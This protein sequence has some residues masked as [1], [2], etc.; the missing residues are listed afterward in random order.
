MN[1][2]F[3]ILSWITAAAVFFLTLTSGADATAAV[4][5]TEAFTA[6]KNLTEALEA[7]PSGSMVLDD[8][9]AAAH[10][11][12]ILGYIGPD[13]APKVFPSDEEETLRLL[14]DLSRVI[15]G[16]DACTD[17]RLETA[18]AYY[19]S[20]WC[21][22]HMDNTVSGKARPAVKEYMKGAL[23]DSVSDE[24]VFAATDLCIDYIERYEPELTGSGYEMNTHNANI[25]GDDDYLTWFRRGSRLFDEGKYS[26]AIEAY[27][28]CLVYREN[29]IRA[30]FEI[31][32]AYI[33]MRK[34]EEAY[35]WLN[36]IYPYLTENSDR[37]LWLRRQGYIEIENMN[38][39]KASA[40]FTYSRTFEESSLARNELLYILSVAPD[41]KQFSPEEAEAY[42]A[43]MGIGF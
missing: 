38:Y 21:I 3:R 20:V 27:Q 9:E 23:G 32:E 11:R 31:A 19:V 4:S 14:K 28:H 10:C 18:A 36:R 2:R 13:L 42:L 15:F 30:S 29:D 40:L 5:E 16:N 7:N 12:K 34:Y 35:V 41:T 33:A 8:G 37:A 26:E 6:L 39:E 43:D 22:M 25:Q 17:T 1:R 24:T